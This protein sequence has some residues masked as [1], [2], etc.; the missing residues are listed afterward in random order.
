[1]NEV[2]SADKLG[3]FTVG[4]GAVA[5]TLFAG[6]ELAR[7]HGRTPVGSYT[8]LG[9]LTDAA[10]QAGSFRILTKGNKGNEGP[11]LA[12]VTRFVLLVIFCSIIRIRGVLGIRN[13][14]LCFL[15]YLL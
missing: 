13:H 7:R 10:G 4:M 2:T 11:F 15:S 9:W 6:V 8:Q 1:M 14:F 12:Y 3:L 5:T